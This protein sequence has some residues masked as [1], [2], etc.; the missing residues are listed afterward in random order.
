M[1]KK[2]HLGP[3][4]TNEIMK[5]AA[6]T[7]EPPAQLPSHPVA[8]ALPSVILAVDVARLQHL[9]LKAEVCQ[10]RHARC[11]AELKIAEANL[12]RS[13][14][15]LAQAV[16]NRGEFE[17]ALMERY[18]LKPTDKLNMDTGEIIRGG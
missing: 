1:S 5:A 14:G 18:Q 9:R 11:Q 2:K 13:E 4:S 10:E 6:L 12:Q 3:R 15:E 7:G 8:P 16:K 17:G